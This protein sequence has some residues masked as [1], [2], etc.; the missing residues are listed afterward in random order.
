M[1]ALGRLTLSTRIL[2][3]P[4]AR[5][6][7][8]PFRLTVR[9]CGG[10]GLAST[11]LLSARGLLEESSASLAL[12]AIEAEDRPLCVQLFGTE[13][14]EMA[15]AARRM[16]DRGAAA[17]DINMGCSVPKIVERG[18]GAALLRR[19]A[20][21]VRLLA[22][23][24]QAVPLPVTAKLRLGW[25][26]TCLTASDL[27]ADLVSAGAAG[28]IVHG[29][30]AEQKFTGEVLL[31]PIARV[32]ERVGTV[33]V[34]GNG[35]VRSPQ[36]AARMIAQTGVAGV[37]IGRAAKRYPW[38]LRDA[39]AYL[40]TGCIPPPPTRRQWLALIRTHFEHLHRLRGERLACAIFRQRMSYYF[41]ALGLPRADRERFR[42][43]AD[44]QT[45]DRFMRSIE[46]ATA[47]VTVP[48]NTPVTTYQPSSTA[49]TV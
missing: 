1:L 3:A 4:M 41:A 47:D 43:F 2:L 32:V 27:A 37:M 14:Y 26:R 21:A 19:P 49:R 45:F 48:R 36:D 23:V 39:H 25:D 40:S 35:D 33:P 18:A 30:T 17:I 15:E 20:Q 7:D 6:G 46:E 5:I 22:A 29:R 44:A 13:P 38:L 28:I 8:A 11:E 42:N 24:V 12:A 31:E 9:H 10:V 34:I 16:A